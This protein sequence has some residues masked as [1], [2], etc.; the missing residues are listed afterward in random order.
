[1]KT[2]VNVFWTG[3]LD[4]T[5][6]ICQ[7]SKLNVDIYP[8]YFR[9]PFRRNINEELQAINIMTAKISQREDTKATLQPLQI[10]EMEQIDDEKEIIEAY[11]WVKEHSV[12]EF[13]LK[14]FPIQYLYLASF[15]KK[16]GIKCEI[17]M[18]YEPHSRIFSII[19][20]YGALQKVKNNEI[21][22]F[23]LDLENSNP[24]LVTLLQYF[25]YPIPLF[26]MSKL[27]EVEE[28]KKMEME[29]VMKDTWFCHHPI[30][31]KPCGFCSPCR[32]V[33]AAKMSYRL[34]Q[35]AIWRNRFAYVFLL[36]TDKLRP[37]AKKVFR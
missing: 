6:R 10:I 28:Y 5:Y 1:M 26:Y 15:C 27:D 18:E 14:R 16:K 8:F 20:K 22:Y 17:G 31:G 23:Q 11:N 19:N 32:Q 9:F 37:L 25:Y 7:L 36:W 30:N 12:V 4:S 21:A 34:P 3:G 13:G 33:V 2:R 24:Y 35:S 29:D